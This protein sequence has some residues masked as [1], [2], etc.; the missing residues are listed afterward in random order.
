MCYAAFPRS[1]PGVTSIWPDIGQNPGAILVNQAYRVGE[2]PL[3]RF[4]REATKRNRE[5]MIER[6]PR[7]TG[8][9]SKGR[10]K[11]SPPHDRRPGGLGWRMYTRAV[12]PGPPG[13]GG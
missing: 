7:K 13:E 4:A 2:V 12:P 9:E 11:P 5:L 1:L 6:Q 8:V 10:P 3:Q